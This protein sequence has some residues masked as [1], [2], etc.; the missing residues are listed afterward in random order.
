M[1]ETIRDRW[2]WGLLALAIVVVAVV[3]AIFPSLL[4]GTD[5]LAGDGN[6]GADQGPVQITRVRCSECPMF[7]LPQELVVS[8]GSAFDL[9]AVED[10]LSGD[11]SFAWAQIGPGPVTVPVGFTISN[12]S[13]DEQV[14][15]NSLEV[16]LIG[17]QEVPQ[18]P[19]LGCLPPQG[20]G[21]VEAISFQVAIDTARLDVAIVVPL[22]QAPDE[23]TLLMPSG[24]QPYAGD[25]DLP[26]TGA[27]TL[28]MQAEYDTSGGETRTA[29]SV[30]LEVLVVPQAVDFLALAPEQM[31]EVQ[32]PPQG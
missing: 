29:R 32:C 23:A 7:E 10:R 18:N 26:Q 1:W 28:Q 24:V 12:D 21:L 2:Q 6:G 11:E 14:V 9:Q 16:I 17:F 31:P 25:I 13:S 3:W 20:G 30:P 22:D 5:Q 8:D 15:I 4:G 27:Y 19:T